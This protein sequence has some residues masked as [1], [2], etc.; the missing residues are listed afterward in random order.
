VSA[1]INAPIKAGV[2]MRVNTSGLPHLEQGGRRLGAN[3]NF[4]GS[5]GGISIFASHPL[6]KRAAG[7][8]QRP[9]DTNFSLKEPRRSPSNAICTSASP[10]SQKR[11]SGKGT[12]RLLQGRYKRDFLLFHGSYHVPSLA[13]TIAGEVLALALDNQAVAVVLDFVNPVGTGRNLGSTG[14][15]AK[16]IG[17]GPEIGIRAEKANPLLERDEV[18]LIRFGIPKSG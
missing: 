15:D 9:S 14:R 3:L 4:G 17:H 10:W 13:R 8:I 6:T 11:C 7:T 2:P 12:K 5:F 16:L 18:R 1:I